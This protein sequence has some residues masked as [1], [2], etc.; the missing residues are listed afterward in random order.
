MKTTQ[1]TLDSISNH[2][3]ESMGVRVRPSRV[4]LSPVPSAKDSCRRPTRGFGKVEIAHLVSDP[5][6][7]RSEFDPE[8]LGMLAADIRRRGQLHPIHVRW[9]DELQKWVIITGERRWRASQQAELTWV[10]CFFHEEPLTRAE[11]LELQMVENLLRDDL[12]PIEEAIAFR[13]L[14]AINGWNAKQVAESL[15]VPA[16][17]VCRSLALLNLPPDI[18]QQVDNGHLPA[19]TAYELS[20]LKDDSQRRRMATKAAAGELT[21][22]QAATIARTGTTKKTD[23]QLTLKRTFYAENGWTVTVSSRKAG[24]YHDVEQALLQALDEVRLRLSN[25][26][27]L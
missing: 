11:V 10:D 27:R 18:K 1:S 25:N 14:M 20:K 21:H 23:P 4:A 15:Q 13:E 7:P 17:K 9:S 24:S 8:S 2:I 26:I 19:R 16:S 3:D 22:A 12:K 6:Q 5:D